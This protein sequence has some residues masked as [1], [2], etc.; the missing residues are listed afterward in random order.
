ML[1]FFGGGEQNLDHIIVWLLALISHA[2]MNQLLKYVINAGRRGYRIFP[3][4]RPEKQCLV[5]LR[6]PPEKKNFCP[7]PRKNSMRDEAR[8]FFY[9]FFLYKNQLL[10]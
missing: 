2:L 4:G 7:P 10:K 5:N 3:G 9:L 8:F 6:P 1:F